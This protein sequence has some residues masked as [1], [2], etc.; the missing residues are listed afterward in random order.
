[1]PMRTFLLEEFLRRYANAYRRVSAMD[2]MPHLLQPHTRIEN[3]MTFDR[4][5]DVRQCRRLIITR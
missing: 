4:D 1:M 3:I 5:A 2:S